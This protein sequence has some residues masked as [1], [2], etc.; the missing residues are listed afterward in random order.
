MY[1]TNTHYS[2]FDICQCVCLCLCGGVCACLYVCVCL[3]VQVETHVLACLNSWLFSWNTRPQL[4]HR[5]HF[6]LPF[7][8]I[9]ETA[10]KQHNAS[11]SLSL[12]LSPSLSLSF[13]LSLYVCVCVCVF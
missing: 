10:T 2:L 5:F 13:F 4:H 11:L 7:L 9:K 12:S 1:H 8:D 3:C 6:K